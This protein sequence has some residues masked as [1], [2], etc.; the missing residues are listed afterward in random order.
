MV[1]LEYAEEET[2]LSGKTSCN[3]E[4]DDDMGGDWPQDPNSVSTE[5]NS[6]SRVT[7]GNS[8]NECGIGNDGEMLTL[9]GTRRSTLPNDLDGSGNRNGSTTP[10]DD[11]RLRR[12]IAN[13]NERRRMQSINAGFQA[14]RSLLPRKDGEKMSKAAILQH[15]AEYIQTLQEEKSRLID[16]NNAMSAAQSKKR[17]IAHTEF[18][19]NIEISEGSVIKGHQTSPAEIMDYLRTIED[20][21]LALSKEHRL[22]VIYEREVID[23]KTK[24]MQDSAV[25]RAAAGVTSLL[26]PQPL[27][28]DPALARS[29]PSLLMPGSNPTLAPTTNHAD[30]LLLAASQQV[31]NNVLF[32]AAVAAT[33]PTSLSTVTSAQLSPHRQPVVTNPSSPYHQPQIRSTIGDLSTSSGISSPVCLMDTPSTFALPNANGNSGVLQSTLQDA[34]NNPQQFSQRNL[35]AI[36]E[37][38]RHIEGGNM[39]T[40]VAATSSPSPHSADL[41][42]LIPISISL[43]IVIIFGGFLLG[44]FVFV[45]DAPMLPTKVIAIPKPEFNHSSTIFLV[46][47]NSIAFPCQRSSHLRSKEIQ[48]KAKQLLLKIVSS[49]SG[50]QFKAVRSRFF[51][52]FRIKVQICFKAIPLFPTA[53]L[54]PQSCCKAPF[55]QRYAMLST[56]QFLLRRG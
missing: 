29:E 33:T 31:Y 16:K 9:N 26:N 38:I 5:E 32:N 15:T 2:L 43:L 7:S 40:R 39:A 1:K 18:V 50:Y 46:F 36:I 53:D 27:N 42:Q 34:A 37:A 10:V 44:C 24:S 21:K 6:P 48:T 52:I 4:D 25:F 11:R 19:E 45:S 8:S 12:Q 55:H 20:L 56:A 54:F 41:L 23:M 49:E 14:L 30:S 28:F 17:R 51:Q 13:C 3:E 35:Q 47:N 22:R